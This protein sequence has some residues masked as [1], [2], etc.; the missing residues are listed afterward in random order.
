MLKWVVNANFLTCIYR[1]TPC[2]ELIVKFS[3]EAQ[4]QNKDDL[5]DIPDVYRGETFKILFAAAAGIFIQ[6]TFDVYFGNYVVF[7]RHF[8]PHVAITIKPWKCIMQPWSSGIGNLYPGA[9]AKFKVPACNIAV[10]YA[11]CQLTP[12]TLWLAAANHPLVCTYHN[13]PPANLWHKIIIITVLFENWSKLN[14][15]VFL[16]NYLAFFCSP[17]STVVIVILKRY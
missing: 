16:H 13:N 9:A 7:Y 12:L 4:V 14:F 15:F 8:L 5:V 3:K 10:F 2:K 17:I 6:Q 11:G 1:L